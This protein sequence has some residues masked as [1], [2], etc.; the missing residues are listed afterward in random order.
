[1]KIE[2]IIHVRSSLSS[3]MWRTIGVRRRTWCGT[4]RRILF[5]RIPSAQ[6]NQA[7]KNNEVDVNE[8]YFLFSIFAQPTPH[9]EVVS[10][11][12][13]KMNATSAELLCAI[14]RTSLP[15]LLLIESL[16]MFLMIYWKNGKH[17]HNKHQ[18]SCVNL[19]IWILLGI[20]KPPSSILTTRPNCFEK[21][22]SFPTDLKVQWITMMLEMF[23]LAKSLVPESGRLFKASKTSSDR[24]NQERPFQI[25]QIAFHQC[26]NKLGGTSHYREIECVFIFPLMIIEC[27]YLF[28]LFR[29]HQLGTELPYERLSLEIVNAKS[30]VIFCSQCYTE[31]KPQRG[32]TSISSNSPMYIDKNRTS[33]KLP[34]LAFWLSHDALWHFKE[35]WNGTH[36]S[37]KCILAYLPSS[38]GETSA[39]F[40]KCKESKT[41]VTKLVVSRAHHQSIKFVL[42]YNTIISHAIIRSLT[43]NK[44]TCRCTPV[45]L[46]SIANTPEIRNLFS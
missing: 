29:V 15:F 36:L 38:F 19:A 42:R 16:E 3:S 26:S 27:S 37:R 17:I 33:L 41:P 7:P 44:K 25:V 14:E 21:Q 30:W 35:T 10:S 40:T 2:Y 6:S 31:W 23:S 5:D 32:K 34:S 20:P 46:L 12:S 43:C 11:P 9:N 39:G 22:L 8:D 28:S 45:M 4:G 18:H 24:Y 1:M 13:G